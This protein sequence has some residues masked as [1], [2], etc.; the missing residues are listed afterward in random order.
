MGI[1]QTLLE[2]GW[3]C[4]TRDGQGKTK[5]E[6]TVMMKTSKNSQGNKTIFKL[7]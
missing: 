7:A 2:L 5:S 4:H 3:R 1:G 6:E